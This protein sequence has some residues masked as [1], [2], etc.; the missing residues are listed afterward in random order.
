MGRGGHAHSGPPPDPNALR[1]ER[2][3]VA[4]W[5][6]LP[7]TGRPGP[8]PDWPLTP[9]G[10]RESWHWTR[11]WKTPQATQW[12]VLGQ[13]V[14]VAIYVRRLV[15]VEQPGATAS[16]GNHVL[17][18]AEGLGLTIPG[19]LRNRWQIG[20]Q[21]AAPVKQPQVPTGTDGSAPAASSARGRLLRAVPSDG[22]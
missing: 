16:L 11:L 19:L 20:S 10:N 17:R 6:V 22:S 1:N 2:N 14:E 4:G 3:D 5:K 15:E 12:E 21:Q 18:L 9:A 8:A 13:Q 7:A